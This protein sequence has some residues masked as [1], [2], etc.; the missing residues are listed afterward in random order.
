MSLTKRVDEARQAYRRGDRNAA[1]A[2]HERAR[3]AHGAREEHGGA[4]D[5]YVGDLVYGG[6]DGVV[7]TF[8]VVSGVVGASLG[9][10][11]ILILGFA[12]LLAD[13][14]AMASGAY[15]STKSEAEYYH[16][17]EERERW[18]VDNYPDGE[19]AE[20]LEIY[21][22]RGYSEEEAGQLVAIQSRDPERWVKAMMVDELSMLPDE[23][24][25]LTSAGATL[26]AFVLAGS[27][28]LLAYFA[29][30]FWTIP[31]Q[32]AFRA[33]VVLTGIA[34]FSLGAAKVFVTHRN[35]VRSGLEMLVV[36]GLA[37]TAAYIVGALLKGLAG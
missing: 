10:Q 4:G 2:A 20:L 8:A 19:R 30:I 37:A 27:L 6:L 23:R 3:I 11:V 24:K 13:G 33:S 26:A 28:P 35:P 7:T 9:S 34:L 29:G 17:E 1:Q 31:S 16:R 15:L 18:E 12:N 21:R 32:A 14:F 22:Q 25:P 5:L 36:G